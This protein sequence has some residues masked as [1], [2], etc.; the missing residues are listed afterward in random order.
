MMFSSETR[1]DILS[2]LSE[3]KKRENTHPILGGIISSSQESL[4]K[5]E[6]L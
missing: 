5:N 4:E 3:W 2:V 1:F 6:I